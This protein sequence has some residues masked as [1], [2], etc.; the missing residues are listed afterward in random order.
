MKECGLPGIVKTEEKDLRILVGQTEVAQDIPEP[1]EDEHVEE[2]TPGVY[3]K[4]TADL[5]ERLEPPS[6]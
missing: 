2:L 6:R 4:M 3:G 5:A 1:I